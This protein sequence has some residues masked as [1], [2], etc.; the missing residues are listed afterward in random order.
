MSVDEL[1]TIVHASKAEQ[2][3]RSLVTKLKDIIPRQMIQINI[4]VA[5]NNKILARETLKAFRKDVTAKLVSI[6]VQQVCL[7]FIPSL[8]PIY[9]S[10]FQS[11]SQSIKISRTLEPFTI[12]ILAPVQI[13]SKVIVIPRIRKSW[14]NNVF[15]SSTVETSQ[16]K[17]NYWL[18]RNRA[19]RKWSPLPTST[20]PEKHSSKWSR[21]NMTRR[22]SG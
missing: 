15:Y 3:A 10:K 5:V 20:F 12:P 11:N 8:F 7:N 9:F 1:S 13:I 4:Q 21:N 16:E 18:N 2:R 14:L 22:L 17:W 6:L 19:S